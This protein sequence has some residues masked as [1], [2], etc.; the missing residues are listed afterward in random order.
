MGVMDKLKRV[1]GV[2]DYD[3]EYEEEYED[4]DEMIISKK[5]DRKMEQDNAKNKVMN[6]NATAQLKVVLVK[7]EQ[8]EDASS[9]ADHLN[10]RRTVVLNL[11]SASKDLSLIH[12]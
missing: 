8:F 9:I 3:D 6:I 2:D 4:T 12:I 1:M 11:E 10:E 5:E 7:P